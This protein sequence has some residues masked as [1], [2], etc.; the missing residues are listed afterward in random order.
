[1]FLELLVYNECKIISILKLLFFFKCHACT[2]KGLVDS[3]MFKK[4]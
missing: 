3:G 1:M 2:E 4:V